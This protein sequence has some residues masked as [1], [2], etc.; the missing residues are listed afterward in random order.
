MRTSAGTFNSGTFATPH[1]IDVLLAWS[2]AADDA[3]AAYLGWRD[4]P[5][6]CEAEA[7]AVYR[8]ALDRE[9]AGARALQGVTNENA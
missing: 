1:A 6:A 9:E 7:F 8:A 2:D 3:Y 5:R 4:A